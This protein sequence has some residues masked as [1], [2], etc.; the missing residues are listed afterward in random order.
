MNADHGRDA[1][2]EVGGVPEALRADRLRVM[3]SVLSLQCLADRHGPR[4]RRA[5]RRVRAVDVR[6]A[7]GG[8]R[9]DAVAWEG[10]LARTEC[11]DPSQIRLFPWRRNRD[12]EAVGRRRAR[13][14]PRF[15]REG[16]ARFPGQARALGARQHFLEGS[17]PL[18]TLSFGPCRRDALAREAAAGVLVPAVVVRCDAHWMLVEAI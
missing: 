12:V 8:D 14:A 17:W 6:G 10:D 2:V 1:V 7:V 13:R 4:R 5:R 9:G 18:R 15:L 3:R 11:P 16:A